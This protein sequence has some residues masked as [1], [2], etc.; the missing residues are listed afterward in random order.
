MR[1]AAFIVGF[2]LAVGCSLARAG[3]VLIGAAR[4]LI[5]R[6]RFTVIRFGVVEAVTLLEPAILATAAYVLLINRKAPSSASVGEATA[7]LAGG[8]VAVWGLVLIAWTF[9]SWRELFVGHAILA[10]QKLVTGGAYGLVRHPVYLAALL[11]WSGLSV[12][13]LSPEAATVTALYVVPSYLLYIRTEEAMML[14]SFGD[15]YRRYR[16][17]VPMLLPRPRAVA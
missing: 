6:S 8:L 2:N 17:R 16:Q 9:S 7:A 14:E 4:S 15:E 10:D 3:G 11:V 1:E 13:F 12:C 5:T